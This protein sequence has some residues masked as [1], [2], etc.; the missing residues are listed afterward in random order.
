MTLLRCL[1]AAFAVSLALAIGVFLRPVV[2]AQM[3]VDYHWQAAPA[4]RGPMVTVKIARDTAWPSDTYAGEVTLISGSGDWLPIT[5]TS[6]GTN[7]DTVTLASLNITNVSNA[8]T[9]S[10]GPTGGITF[11]ATAQGILDI[12]VG[13]LGT[14]VTLPDGSLTWQKFTP[15]KTR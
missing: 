7:L 1:Y 8:T 4:D 5:Q 3:A 12:P 6:V 9:F 13:E 2:R 10:N 14:V 15:K 11:V